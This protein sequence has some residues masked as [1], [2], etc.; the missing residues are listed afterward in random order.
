M[1]ALG[2]CADR[3]S[4]VTIAY[5]GDLSAYRRF[6][7][8]RYATGDGDHAVIPPF[9][10]AA[11]AEQIATSGTLQLVVTVQR[12]SGPVLARDSLAPRPLAPR[13][14][15]GVNVA[16]STRRPATS[17]CSGHWDATPLAPPAV[18]SLYVSVTAYER[19]KPP[20]CD[21]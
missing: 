21:D 7:H 3:G 17:R 10:S 2:A 4:D 11:R 20:R 13:M 1:L 15:Y 19:G 16:V 18:E 14:S 8:V 6:V 9:P 12:D 5:R